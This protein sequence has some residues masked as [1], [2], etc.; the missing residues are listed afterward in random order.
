M[1]VPEGLVG[2]GVCGEFSANWS[3]ASSSAGQ[4]HVVV[5]HRQKIHEIQVGDIPADA[6]ANVKVHPSV[7]VHV[8]HQG[9]PAPVGGGNA[10][11]AGYVANN[12]CRCS[13]A[14]N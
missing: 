8:K 9:T 1:G 6:V 3:I 12:R 14:G 2:K 11:I 13:A 5:Y 10:G 7:V 4:H